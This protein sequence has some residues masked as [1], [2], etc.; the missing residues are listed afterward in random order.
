MWLF[1]APAGAA[2]T[3]AQQFTAGN[4]VATVCRVPPGTAEDDVAIVS[5]V[6]AGT[7]NQL[8]TLI[9]AINCWAITEV[10]RWDKGV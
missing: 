3:I 5:A 6:P 2:M 4:A 9:P 7:R 8:T 10:S 1:L